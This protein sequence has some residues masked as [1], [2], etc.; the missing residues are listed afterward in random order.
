[1]KYDTTKPCTDII[2]GKKRM[3]SGSM[4]QP[5]IIKGEAYQGRK[6][7]NTE[8]LKNQIRDEETIITL[9]LPLHKGLVCRRH[10]KISS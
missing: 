2:I 10:G 9:K 3:D 1:M 7:S 5:Q 4:I 8:N 6:N